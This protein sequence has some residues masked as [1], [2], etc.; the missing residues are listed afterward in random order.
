MLRKF[1][2]H[3]AGVRHRLDA[4]ALRQLERKLPLKATLVREPEN[5]ADT[6]AI[7]VMVRRG[8]VHMGYVPAGIAATLALRLDAGEMKVADC[9]VIEIDSEHMSAEARVKLRLI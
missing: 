2:F 5:P 3:V 7:K 6:N 9:D 4:T 1:N 8:Q